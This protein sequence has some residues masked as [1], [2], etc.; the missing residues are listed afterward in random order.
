ME[1]IVY[2]CIGAMLLFG[3]MAVMLHSILKSAISLA[4]AS[5]SLGVLMYTMGAVWTALFEISVCSGL[6]TVIFISAI[7]LS[8]TDKSELGKLYEDRK[9]MSL[10]PVILIAGGLILFAAAALQL[11]SMPDSAT[12]TTAA[13]DFMEI[14]WNNR[15]ADIWG[16]MIVAITGSVAVVALFKE[17]DLL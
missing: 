17:R 6:V 16:Q 2:I 12:V 7:S 8:N 13:N 5:A 14:L 10:L 9:R 4:L 3:I 11:F 15:Q 1:A